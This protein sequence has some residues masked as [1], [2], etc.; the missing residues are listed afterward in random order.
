MNNIFMKI[1]IMMK[2][3]YVIK[4][5]KEEDKYGLLEITDEKLEELKKN[6]LHIIKSIKTH[7]SFIKL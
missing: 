2:K 1:L 6:K 3:K 4:Y 5:N 7:K